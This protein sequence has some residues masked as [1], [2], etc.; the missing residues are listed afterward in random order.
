MLVLD[1]SRETTDG[2][3]VAAWAKGATWL[4][5]IRVALTK[6]LCKV[7]HCYAKRQT[8]HGGVLLLDSQEKIQSVL[9]DYD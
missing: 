7:T 1:C 8:Q 9:A 3:I 4:S 5:A 6:T 2:K